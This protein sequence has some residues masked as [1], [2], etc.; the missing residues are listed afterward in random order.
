METFFAKIQEQF[1]GAETAIEVDMAKTSVKKARSS[2]GAPTLG[3]RTACLSVKL[4]PETDAQAFKGSIET[5]FNNL[6]VANPGHDAKFKSTQDVSNGYIDIAFTY[7]KGLI[8]LLEQVEKDPLLEKALTK[9]IGEL[10]VVSDAY[11]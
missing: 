7:E 11:N 4:K 2:A 8:V 1:E 5:W 3:I 6:A 9:A 10:G